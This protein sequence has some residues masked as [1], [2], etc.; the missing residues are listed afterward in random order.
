MILAYYSLTG[1]TADFLDWYF[2]EYEKRNIETWDPDG[3]YVLFTPTYNFGEVPEEVEDWLGDINVEYYVDDMEITPLNS[4]L[5]EAVVASGN[6]NF[7][8]AYA[9]SGDK[10]SEEYGVPLLMKYELKGNP[11]IAEAVKEEMARVL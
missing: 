7:G 1:N 11:M 10:I 8:P 3:P 5:M 9:A 2:P 4:D 6:R